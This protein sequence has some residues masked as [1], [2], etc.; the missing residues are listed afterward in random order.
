MVKT[1][2]AISLFFVICLTMLFVPSCKENK[3]AL[4][5]Q[6]FSLYTKYNKK[7]SGTL[8]QWNN[9][10]L[11]DSLPEKR[12]I[13]DHSHKIIA[14][15]GSFLDTP[16]NTLISY[17]LA[18]IRGFSYV[19]CDVRWTKD[20]VPVLL[21][22]ST[23]EA[24]SDGVGYISKLTFE[25]VRQYDFGAHKG[26]QF[27]GTKIP[28]FEEFI[29]LCSSLNLKAYIELKT[30]PSTSELKD[31]LKIIERYK[32]VD[33]VTY[34]SFSAILLKNISKTQPTARLAYLTLAMS[35]DKK[36]SILALRNGQNEVTCNISYSF[37]TKEVADSLKASGI[38]LEVW[39]LTVPDQVQNLLEWGV[40]GITTNSEE[41]V[42]E[43]L[44]K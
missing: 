12:I 1:L 13:T 43:I 14:H 35:V 2:K 7:Y 18:K 29:S 39:T 25:Q 41:V 31:L 10:L 23:I 22:D 21:H 38:P 33:N 28:S 40:S 27:T 34:M 15:K 9:A 17:V 44:K 36:E 16:E 8:E 6:A 5:E 4:P 20:G 32:M 24:T 26:E 42:Q 3:P 37:L 19:E 11:N 30:T